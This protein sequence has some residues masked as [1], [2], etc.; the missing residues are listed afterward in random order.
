MGWVI[1]MLLIIR[2]KNP[3]KTRGI[4]DT[5]DRNEYSQNNCDYLKEKGKPEIL[6]KIE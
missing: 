4:F 5:F 3:I 2:N 6:I 1:F